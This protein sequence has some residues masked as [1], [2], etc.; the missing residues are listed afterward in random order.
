MIDD[1]VAGCTT[2]GGPTIIIILAVTDTCSNNVPWSVVVL[3]V[4]TDLIG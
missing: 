4:A 3:I 1:S 2:G